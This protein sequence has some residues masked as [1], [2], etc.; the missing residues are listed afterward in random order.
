MFHLISQS[1]VF[2]YEEWISY[3]SMQSPSSTIKHI[4]RRYK[5]RSSRY[6]INVQSPRFMDLSWHLHLSIDP[7]SSQVPY[8]TSPT[9]LWNQYIVSV[10]HLLS[11]FLSHKNQD[12]RYR[13]GYS[14]RDK[15]LP[16]LPHLNKYSYA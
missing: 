14:L 9:K 15:N 5:Q 8:L 4:N 13:S 3:Q 11:A 16:H 2:N 10:W 6:H 7:S 12:Y 1:I